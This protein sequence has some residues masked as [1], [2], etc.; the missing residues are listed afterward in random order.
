MNTLDDHVVVASAKT[1]HRRFSAVAAFFDAQPED[2]RYW[3]A[4][5]GGGGV[6][7]PVELWGLLRDAAKMLADEGGV[8]VGPVPAT[9]GLQ[10]AAE[11][12]A[13]P[14]PTLL[15]CVADGSV[16]LS[17]SLQGPEENETVALKDI[18]KLREQLSRERE[19]AQLNFAIENPPVEPVGGPYSWDGEQLPVAQPFAEVYPEPAIG[20]PPISASPVSPGSPYNAPVSPSWQPAPHVV[21]SSPQV[22]PVSTPPTSPV[23]VR[24]TS[25]AP[26]SGRAV[27]RA[28]VRMHSSVSVPPPVSAPATRW[29]AN[30]SGNSAS[31]PNVAAQPED[32]APPPVSA[33]PTWYTASRS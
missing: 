4:D 16:P 1:P 28:A 2:A 13:I 8:S 9:F 3:L 23:V 32:A 25:A 19:V 11:F 26:T 31:R 24:P 27:A 22:V 18:V 30:W 33:P 14:L 20:P 15:Q 17:E 5:T 10:E 29:A 6:E 12:A 7:L 21:S